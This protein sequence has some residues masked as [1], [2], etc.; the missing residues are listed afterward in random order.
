LTGLD[1]DFSPPSSPQRGFVPA[2][3]AWMPWRLAVIF[4]GFAALWTAL[5]DPI[6]RLALHNEARIAASEPYKEW[7]F[8]L[9]FTVFVFFLIRRYVG[10]I[11]QARAQLGE[12]EAHFRRL[13]E[14]AA[15][16]IVVMDLSRSHFVQHNRQAELLFEA[17][18]EE[19]TRLGPAELSPEFQPDGQRSSEKARSY[20]Q[21]AADGGAPVF[22]WMHRSRSG[23]E[24]PCEIRLLRF[25]IREELLIR[26]SITDI[27]ERR[28]SQEALRESERR[29]SLI[30]NNAT[31]MMVLCKVEPGG[32]FRVVSVNK[33]YL[34]SVNAAG[35][36]VKESDLIGRTLQEINESV[37][38]FP[39]GYNREK[40]ERFLTVVSS[41]QRLAYDDVHETPS[42]RC[43][44][45]TVLTPL[46]DDSGSCSFVL[47]CSRDVTGQRRAA[48]ALAQSEENYRTLF[49]QSTDAVFLCAP[50]GKLIDVNKRALQLTSFSRDEL[51]NSDVFDI[52]APEDH[53]HLRH[54]LRDLQ[55]E[56]SRFNIY[57]FHRKDGGVF[58][59]ETHTKL[60]PD[61]RLLAMVRDITERRV[62]EEQRVR[63]EKELRQAQKIQAIGTLAGGIAHDFNN[64][65]AAILGNAQLLKLTLAPAH[66]GH[67][68]VSQIL[69]ASH[70]AKDLVQQI[71]MFSRQ[72]E[73]AREVINLEPL[74]R[75]AI[76]LISVSLSSTIQLRVRVEEN[77]PSVLADPTQIHQVLI[78]LCTNALHAMRAKG[79][80]LDVSLSGISL[81]GGHA[82]SKANLPAGRYVLLKIADTGHGMSAETMERMYEPFFTTKPVGE[83]TGLG[84][85][86][87]HGIVQSND[88]AITVASTVG[89]GTT[90]KLYFPAREARPGTTQPWPLPAA[91]TGKG[92]HVVFVDDE[93]SIAEVA[94]IMLGK[95][96][97]RT[98]VFTD[99]RQ[100]L[101]Y[102]QTSSEEIS[103]LMTD[104][105]MPS[106]SGIEL[107]RG[108][109]RNQPTIPA[110]LLTGY[111]KAFDSNAAVG[112]NISDVIHK[113]FTMEQLAASIETALAKR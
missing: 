58:P 110:V 75:E 52:I 69:L 1:M 56:S 40:Q 105:S 45:E 113:P 22:E 82:D 103:L 104:L 24:I 95:L 59:G 79:G 8:V 38:R 53:D 102:F 28:R 6:L 57:H 90:F 94:R 44:G 31:D 77:V 66:E 111:G 97:Y 15:D 72:R 85:A 13:I 27:T 5:A 41:R 18:G 14:T 34:N 65:L 43:F 76:D 23:R 32:L 100:A 73:Q 86:V 42:G 51:L 106:I 84:L 17:T 67:S 61:G 112:L 96:G 37:Y 19:L 20:L 39:S 2:S 35:F 101:L 89:E 55:S 11:E 7:G 21:Q 74:L 46:L 107:I 62:A 49:D 92:E 33:T 48:E 47:Y 4:F 64:I 16:A 54:C 30:L 108:V 83:G 91:K 60:L 26:G 99:P 70:R 93:V 71:L 81:I 88:G 109:N 36:R 9:L 25:P 80:L 78:N 87:V 68:N 3:S 12:S 98:T 50:E 10:E 29:L 63:L